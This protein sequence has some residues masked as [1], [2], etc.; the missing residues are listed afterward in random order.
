MK[1][2]IEEIRFK[3]VQICEDSEFI[4]ALIENKPIEKLWNR[5]LGTTKESEIEICLKGIKLGGQEL[6][7]G[8]DSLGVMICRQEVIVS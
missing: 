1:I 8:I 5:Q 3:A 7:I 2:V 4:G 6:S